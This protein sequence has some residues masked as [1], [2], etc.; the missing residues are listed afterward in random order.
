MAEF[1][2]YLD[3]AIAGDRG[4]LAALL[5]RHG[6]SV[7]RSLAGQIPRRHQSLLSE[8]DVMQQ[9]YA[10]ATANIR[11]FRSR[12]NEEAFA[13]WL[14]TIAQHNVSDCRP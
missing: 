8:D 9:T 2:D 3:R 10:D 13:G 1:G 4:A 7:R 11:Q 12:D 6:P 14:R 5:K